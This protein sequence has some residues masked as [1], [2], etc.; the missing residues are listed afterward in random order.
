[1]G[2]KAANQT[3]GFIMHD[4]LTRGARIPALGFG[5]FRMSGAEVEEILPLALK[6]GF[7]HVD[8][9]QI[10]QN[11]AEVGA[12]LAASKLARGEVFLTTKVWVENFSA[13]RFRPS[14]EESLRKLQTDHVDLLLL[15]WPRFA[16]VPL[17]EQIGLLNEVRAAGLAKDI[18]VSNY[19]SALMRAADALSAA[20]LV[21]NQVEYHPYLSQKAVL[22]AAR[23]G[24]GS[25]TAYYV[26]ADGAVPKDHLLREIGG[27]HGRTPAQVAL[28]WILQQPQAIA[29]SKTA[30]PERV[31]ENFAVFDFSLTEEDMALISNLARPDGR[32]VSPPGLAP[33]WD[34]A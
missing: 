3:G 33:D 32:I 4:V 25:L 17:D 34:A 27:R 14:V 12:A 18:G 20:P 15:H 30:K 19:S 10:Y 28:R 2:D 21:T 5:V 9:A 6:T 26:M 29:L 24:G 7:R 16:E 22:E 31:A 11:E 23:D 8:T 13:A 1:M